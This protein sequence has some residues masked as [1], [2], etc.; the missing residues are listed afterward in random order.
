MK[1][2]TKEIIGGLNYIKTKDQFDKQM[3]IEE[4]TVVVP[5]SETGEYAIND[6]VTKFA[7]SA[8]TPSELTIPNPFLME[9]WK[10]GNIINYKSNHE[11]YMDFDIKFIIL[12]VLY[13][14][15]QTGENGQAG[16]MWEADLKV[17][18][19]AVSTVHM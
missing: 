5:R 16:C 19:G 17:K 3:T 11:K 10:I 15:S 2:E 13:T 18:I 8:I 6:S 7:S 9:H 1:V 14:F 4:E 12:G